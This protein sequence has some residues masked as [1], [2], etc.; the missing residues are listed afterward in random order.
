MKTPK[1]SLVFGA[2]GMIWII[3]SFAQWMIFHPDISQLIFGI[4]LGFG[5]LYVGY[6]H[7]W[8]KKTG[9][10]FRE[11]GREIKELNKVCDRILDYAREIEE[12]NEK[13]SKK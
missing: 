3:I 1:I 10:K 9:K 13:G 4:A 6:G 5:L 7:W 11:I 2:V 8:R 12:K